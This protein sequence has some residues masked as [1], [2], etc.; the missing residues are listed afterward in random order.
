[1]IWT[2]ICTMARTLIPWNIFNM[3]SWTYRL[4]GWRL[5]FSLNSITFSAPALQL[6]HNRPLYRL[7]NQGYKCPCSSR[8]R[9]LIWSHVSRHLINRLVVELISTDWPG[10]DYQMSVQN[11]LELW[12]HLGSSSWS[13]NRTLKTQK[14]LQFDT[15]CQ[16]PRYLD[17]TIFYL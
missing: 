5:G 15:V 4:N 17:L 3:H 13:W 1:M 8:L 16:Y 6:E 7:S 14:D 11:T 12:A 2:Q 10:I 9:N